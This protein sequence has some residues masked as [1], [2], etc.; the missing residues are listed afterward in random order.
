MAFFCFSIFKLIF[1]L[2]ILKHIISDS[3]YFLYSDFLLGEGV[4]ERCVCLQLVYC[5]NRCEAFIHFI[6]GCIMQM[7]NIV[8]N[9]L[10]LNE[11]TSVL[12]HKHIIYILMKC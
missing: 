1:K 5:R 12:L 11:I 8:K 7:K 4:R 10:K 2:I 6:Q 9:D 3:S